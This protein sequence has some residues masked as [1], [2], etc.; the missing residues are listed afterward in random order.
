MKFFTSLTALFVLA[1]TA[2]AL[3][4]PT[5]VTDTSIVDFNSTLEADGTLEERQFN[6]FV[7][8][9]TTSGSPYTADVLRAA[10]TLAN[11]AAIC[12]QTNGSGSKCT[13]MT[14]HKSAAMGICGPVASQVHC[15][16]AGKVGRAVAEQCNVNGLAGGYGQYEWGRIV[17]YVP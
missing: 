7:V 3:V 10:N 17:V 8:C 14:D 9:E 1:H 11:K 6:A 2:V 16:T 5:A 4:V 13:Q 15:K 12:K